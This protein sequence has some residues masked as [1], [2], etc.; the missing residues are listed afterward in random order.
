MAN[1]EQKLQLL[2]KYYKK[3]EKSGD[4]SYGQFQFFVQGNIPNERLLKA[5]QTYAKGIDEKTILGFYDISSSGDGSV[6]YIFTDDK[7]YYRIINSYAF[8]SRIFA[9]KDIESVELIKAPRSGFYSRILSWNSWNPATTDNMMLQFKFYSGK[10]VDWFDFYKYGNPSP[11]YNFWKELLELIRSKEPE[12]KF[13]SAQNSTFPI[14]VMGTHQSGKTTFINALAGQELIPRYG[15]NSEVNMRFWNKK[16]DADSGKLHTLDKEG[17]YNSYSIN[18]SDELR[19]HLNEENLTD[20]IIE[21]DIQGIYSDKKI[22]ITELSDASSKSMLEATK[23]GL[24]I[25]LIHVELFPSDDDV[26]LLQ[27]VAEVTSKNKNLKVIFVISQI[28]QIDPDKEDLNSVIASVEQLIKSVDF[29]EINLMPI[30]A[31]DALILKKALQS[32]PLSRR[33]RM[34]ISAFLSYLQDDKDFETDVSKTGNG[35]SAEKIDIDGTEYTK[36]FLL[37]VLE[38]TGFP[39][40]ETAINNVIDHPEE[41]IQVEPVENEK[42]PQNDLRQLV[43][44]DFF[45]T[46]IDVNLSQVFPVIVMATMSSGKSTLINALL[47]EDI[48]PSQNMACTAK[49]FYLLDDDTATSNKLYLTKKDGSVSCE[50]SNLTEKLKVAN[51]DENVLEI[52][53]TGQIKGVQNTN[54]NLLMIDTPGPNNS[55]DRT[56]EEIAKGIMDKVNGGL[57]LY[58]MNATQMGTNDDKKLL[59]FVSDQL[60]VKPDLKVMFVVNKVDEFE[61]ERESIL[62]CI[63][64]TKNHLISCGFKNPDIVPVSALAALLFNKVEK[65]VELTRTE[66]NNFQKLFDIFY[67][68]KLNLG[69]YSMVDDVSVLSE[70]VNM[71]TDEIPLIQLKDAFANT[72][73]PELER[74]IQGYQILSSSSDPLKINVMKRR[75]N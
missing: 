8:D 74:K 38:Y 11:M 59:E 16:T 50:E 32:K 63:R 48:L 25:Y 19:R 14:Y 15:C 55:T 21:G 52:L 62:K 7:L 36:D 24:I 70:N 30:S 1:H 53:L 68:A 75:K 29:K 13:L 17:N 9:Y 26:E 28:D 61:Q 5:E 72:G 20:A 47:G 56:H 6:G 51:N 39:A 42:A 73:I 66:R 41:Q 18:S 69:V 23:E 46:G 4:S 45:G 37:K 3:I 27:T 64:E 57:I 10:I 67:S 44:D 12:E 33:E 2:K 54:R 49:V 34:G 71:G 60:R 35:R 31:D 65:S 58:V 40:L 43:V 22:E